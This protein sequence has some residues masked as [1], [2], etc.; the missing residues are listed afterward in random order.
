MIL[1]LP[2]T[3]QKPPVV[4]EWSTSW[5]EQARR[6]EGGGRREIQEK[7]QVREQRE[8]VTR[9]EEGKATE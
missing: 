8:E 4:A 7:E 2:G 9:K 3:T 6:D 1:W 5:K